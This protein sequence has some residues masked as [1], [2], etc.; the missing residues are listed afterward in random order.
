[1]SKAS[2]SRQ[3][4]DDLSMAYSFLESLSTAHE[5]DNQNNTILEILQRCPKYIQTKWQ[6]KAL[7]HK[8]E[9]GSYSNF[10]EFVKFMSKMATNWCD[11]REALKAF[12]YRLKSSSVNSFSADSNASISPN[13]RRAVP[14]DCV[15]SG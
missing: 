9:N 7:N 5:I 8:F 15:W 2:D 12:K 3:L 13:P 14:Q 6:N 4:A 1:M 11:G 10:G